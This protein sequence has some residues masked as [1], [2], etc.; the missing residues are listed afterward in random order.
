MKKLLKSLRFKVIALTM[1]LGLTFQI[2]WNAN[3]TEACVECVSLT[4]GLCV[5][6][7]TTS[8]GHDSCTPSQDSC[9]CMVSGTC[10]TDGPAPGDGPNGE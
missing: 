2:G 5:G 7:A 1:L 10:K 6:C 8:T 4:G 9:S 3:E